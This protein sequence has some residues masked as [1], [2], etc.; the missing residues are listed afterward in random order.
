MCWVDNGRGY[1][2]QVYSPE[3]GVKISGDFFFSFF[4]TIF[5]H[6][7]QVDTDYIPIVEILDDILGEQRQH[8]EHKHQVAYDCPT[9]S[10]EIAGLDHGNGHGNFEVNYGLGVYKCWSCGESHNTHGS[11]YK[12]IRKYGTPKQL[13]EYLIL[14]PDQMGEYK[15]EYQK[16]RLPKEFIS[17]NTASSGIKLTPYY[18]RAY[19][20]LKRERYVTDEMIEKYNIGFCYEGEYANRIIIPS[21]NEFDE[22]DFFVGR[23]YLTKPFMKY[24]NPEAEKEAIIFNGLLID[25]TK[26]IYLVEGPFDSIF[27]PNSIAML[28]KKMSDLL[29]KTLYEKANDIVIVLDGDAWNDAEKLYHTLN[30]GRLM[31]KVKVAKLPEDDDIASLRGDLTKIEIKKLD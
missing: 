17:F 15:R 1:Y 8:N 26:T 22:V 29:F 20:Y 12:L 21:Y 5:Y 18:K 14:K 28:G 7:M 27:L 30:V 13:K 3:S 24:K 23:S 19:N 9:C 10:Y 25:W 6:M 11:I 31:G 16:V 4:F 2:S